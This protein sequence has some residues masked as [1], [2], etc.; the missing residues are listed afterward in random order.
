MFAT[1]LRFVGAAVA[2]V[3]AEFFSGVV[4]FKLLS[5]RKLASLKQMLRPPSWASLAPLVLGGATMLGRQAALNIA[6]L[7]A[8]RR[9]QALDPSGVAAAAY[10]I[11][12]QLYYVGIVVH[13]AMQQTAA[14]LVAA[15]RAQ[16]GDHQARNVGDR[17]FVWNSI[18]GVILG[19]TQLV[20]LPWLVP[21][22]SADP[23][24]Q[25]MARIPA[26]LSA[27][28]LAMNGPV[29]AGEGIMLGLRCFRDLM[30]V[31]SGSVCCMI[32]GLSS[33]LAKRSINGIFVSIIAFTAFQAAAVTLHYLKIGPLAVRQQHDTKGNG[34][35]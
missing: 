18:V 22:F 13:V 20:A 11:V 33:P 21:L 28:V 8:G 7:C 1:P 10:G 15:T 19:M 31:T 2:T 32:A 24:I 23:T 35:V 16:A 29:F 27:L 12:M 34:E 26:L 25:D 14:A 4:Y 6:F 5:R 17:M 3:V 30:L 9:A